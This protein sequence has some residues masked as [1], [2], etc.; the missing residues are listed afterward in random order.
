MFVSVQNGRG[1]GFS[2]TARKDRPDSSGRVRGPRRAPGLTD[3]AEA[4]PPCGRAKPLD[5]T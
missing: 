1:L 2:G 5:A 4:I 3:P